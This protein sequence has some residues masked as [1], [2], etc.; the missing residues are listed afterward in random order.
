MDGTF[1]RLSCQDLVIGQTERDHTQGLF[2]GFGLWPQPKAQWRYQICGIGQGWIWDVLR[3]RSL[4]ILL[5]RSGG[6][7]DGSYVDILV[8]LEAWGGRRLLKNRVQRAKLG[9]LHLP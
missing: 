9:G 3:L 6:Q 5:N 8:A 4:W 2:S 7:R 1:K